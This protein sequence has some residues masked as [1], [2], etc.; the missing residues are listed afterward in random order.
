MKRLMLSAAACVLAAGIAGVALAGPAARPGPSHTPSHTPNHTPNPSKPPAPKPPAPGHTQ[1]KPPPAPPAPRPQPP[2]PKPPAPRPQ[3]PAPQPTPPSSSKPAP[4][5]GCNGSPGGLNLTGPT[6]G[7]LLDA[8][9][10]VG[11]KTQ[12]AIDDALAGKLLTD[13]ERNY[14]R[15]ALEKNP[16]LTK[17]EKAALASALQK[18]EEEKRKQRSDQPGGGTVVVVNPPAVVTP[19]GG[20]PAPSPGGEPAP[21]IGGEGA[22]PNT[23][24][25]EAEVRQGTRYLLVKNESGGKLRVFIQFCV[26]N[27]GEEHSWMQ[28]EDETGVLVYEFDAGESARISGKD[29]AIAASKVRIWA[30]ADGKVWNEFKEKDLVLAAKPYRADAIEIFTFTFNP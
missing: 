18:D 7:S 3:P 23:T 17:A 14:I 12:A 21:E 11:P 19:G 10:K 16:N 25:G 22:V 8:K 15:R 28:T 27:A 26:S 29:G 30:E 6:N 4:R 13:D 20:S 5:P 24:P 1:P 2:A 9:N